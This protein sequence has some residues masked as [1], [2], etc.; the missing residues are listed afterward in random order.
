M[1]RCP[2]CSLVGFVGLTFAADE[3]TLKGSFVWTNGD[4]ALAGTR[5]K[6]SSKKPGEFLFQE[7]QADVGVRFGPSGSDAE[8]GRDD[9]AGNDQRQLNRCGG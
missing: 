9:R 8:R 7:S 6:G 2:R 3:Q 4:G 5:A 1:A